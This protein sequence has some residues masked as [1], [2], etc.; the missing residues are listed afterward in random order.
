M[1]HIALSKD[2]QTYHP[3]YQNQIDNFLDTHYGYICSTKGVML[4]TQGK[5]EIEMLLRPS[6]AALNSCNI[7]IS[8]DLS[9]QW[10][11]LKVDGTRILRRS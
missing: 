2:Q 3:L 5:C 1:G 6:R 11:Y 9:T 7:A 10:S 4:V 8:K